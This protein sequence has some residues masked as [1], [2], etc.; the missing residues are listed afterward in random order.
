MLGGLQF[1]KPGLSRHI[2]RDVVI[3]SVRASPQALQL[4]HVLIIRP[5]MAQREGARER[6]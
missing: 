3:P 5:G 1:G 4:V 2:P 6:G